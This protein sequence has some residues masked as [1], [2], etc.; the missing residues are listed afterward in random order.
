[1]D[2]V[3]NQQGG[4]ANPA[5]AGPAAQPANQ[6]PQQPGQAEDLQDEIPLGGQAV[7]LAAE[8]ARIRRG[9]TDTRVIPIHGLVTG[10]YPK[11]TMPKPITQAEQIKVFGDRVGKFH[12]NIDED[13]MH[14]IKKCDQAMI[15][16]GM[17]SKTVATALRSGPLNGRAAMFVDRCMLKIEDEYPASDHYCQQRGQQG[18]A[19]IPF[20]PGIDARS[21]HSS[22]HFADS[23]NTQDS[24]CVG[25]NAEGHPAQ[26]VHG[27]EARRADER[28]RRRRHT[29]ARSAIHHQSEHALVP[30]QPAIPHF[31]EV[32]A[33]ACLRQYLLEQ[34]FKKSAPNVAF[35]E[36]V[37]AQTQ[38]RSISVSEFIWNL[39][40]KHR[41]YK[42]KL[43]GLDAPRKLRENKLDIEEELIQFIKQNTVIE[44]KKF[45]QTKI[46]YNP[47]CMNTLA[48]CEQIAKLFEEETEEGK[49]FTNRTRS[50]A[51]PHLVM[52]AELEQSSNQAAMAA[53]AAAQSL[54][55]WNNNANSGVYT[56]AQGYPIS[57]IQQ[58]SN[59]QNLQPQHYQPEVP[60]CPAN[61]TEEVWQ[62]THA[63]VAAQFGSIS[64]ATAQPRGRGGGTFRGGRGFS[65]GTPQ[66]GGGRGRGQFNRG[67]QRGGAPRGGRGGYQQQQRQP[68]QPP[69]PNPVPQHIGEYWICTPQMEAKCLYPNTGNNKRCA[70]CRVPG[71]SYSGCGYKRDDIFAGNFWDV[72][73]RAG[74]L[75]S[76]KQADAKFQGITNS[77]RKLKVAAAA[78]AGQLPAICNQS[79]QQQ[80]YGG[81]QAQ[82]Q[83]YTSGTQFIQNAAAAQA[84]QQQQYAQQQQEPQQQTQ[85]QQ[86]PPNPAASGQAHGV[87]AAAAAPVQFNVGASSPLR[88][89][90]AAAGT[91]AKSSRQPIDQA[92]VDNI[93]Q[94]LSSWA[95]QR[96][97]Q[98]IK[99]EEQQQSAALWYT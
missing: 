9:F 17:N 59:L 7:D 92:R 67:S 79:Q 78:F 34:F 98:N 56:D 71:H 55:N 69:Q 57:T 40:I 10:Q 68:G 46:T 97:R 73:P 22:V 29:S 60:P 76:K 20:E 28:T 66:R 45:F 26:C 16:L 88:Q 93:H 96:E 19:W 87:S 58:A 5:P 31:E 52:G 23:V 86:P 74:Q 53:A 14:F 50:Q 65:R 42:E 44:F 36:Y 37:N 33:K 91:L 99:N 13:V 41:K 63:A 62:S 61:I 75:P 90:S 38:S 85:Q 77:E 81:Y 94:T 18:R 27:L 2:N 35:Q 11:Q 39:D 15:D 43:W 84:Q 64:A 3:Q 82:N 6:G 51:K 12:G 95:E 21:S 4:N 25:V 48:K 89:M 72:H 49:I 54:N 1:M 70:Y 83:G 30:D 24:I 80:Y 47:D 8:N 32:S